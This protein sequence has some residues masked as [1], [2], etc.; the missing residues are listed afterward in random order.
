MK[1]DKEVL[2]RKENK[3]SLSTKHHVSRGGDF[4]HQRN[5]KEFLND[6]RTH[7]GMNSGRY[8][9][10]YKPLFMFLLSKV[11]KKW[12][13]VYS[14]AKT[15]LDKE[16]PIFWMIALNNSD[17]KEIVRCGQ[18]SYYSGL[19]VNDNGLIQI[20]NPDAIPPDS[21]AY[22]GETLS[23]NGKVVPRLNSE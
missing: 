19:Y 17:K 16:D 23:F 20:V 21:Y 7:I 8:G 9:Y 15:R 4:R 12:A 13:D 5:T 1:R 14:E 22:P 3:A 2:Y 10:D 18:S 11:G 6:E